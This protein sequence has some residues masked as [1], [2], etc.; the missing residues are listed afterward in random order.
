[1][2]TGVIQAGT[3]QIVTWLSHIVL[4]CMQCRAELW[5]ALLE[6]EAQAH[7]AIRVCFGSNALSNPQIMSN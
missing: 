5:A 1:M 2:G 7:S 3:G 6:R 4:P